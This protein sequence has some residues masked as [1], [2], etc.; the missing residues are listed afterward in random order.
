MKHYKIVNDEIVQLVEGP[1]LG[2]QYQYHKVQ[3]LEENDAL[4][5]KFEY[6]ILSGSP[7]DVPEFQQYIGSILHEIIEEQL[8]AHNIVFTGGVDEN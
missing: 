2:I 6:T 3:L 4:K 8:A 5:L 7:S 1:Y